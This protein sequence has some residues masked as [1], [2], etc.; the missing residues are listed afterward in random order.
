[1]AGASRLRTPRQLCP[2]FPFQVPAA[3]ASEPVLQVSPHCTPA[4]GRPGGRCQASLR[5]R[6]ALPASRCWPVWQPVCAQLLGW[7][8]VGTPGEEPLLLN[9]APNEAPGSSASRPFWPLFL[10]GISAE[11]QSRTEQ[12]GASAGPGRWAGRR[13]G[14]PGSQAPGAVRA[15]MHLALAICTE[16][17][18]D[19]P[20]MPGEGPRPQARP[21]LVTQRS[22]GLALWGGQSPSST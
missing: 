13:A 17:A 14:A 2:G 5:Q 3:L 1:M 10:T 22:G 11:G 12:G 21:A 6:V 20:R 15:W 4:R 19:L 18:P 7:E 8:A 16:G 9:W